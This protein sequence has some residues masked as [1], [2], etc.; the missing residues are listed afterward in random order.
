[1][2]A[3]K[4]NRDHSRITIPRIAWVLIA[5]FMGI[6]IWQQFQINQLVQVSSKNS[7]ES[8]QQA[9]A[10]AQS[11]EQVSSIQ[12]DSQ[13]QINSRKVGINK[14]RAGE[15]LAQRRQE[16]RMLGPQATGQRMFEELKIIAGEDQ[17]V[18]PA[19]LKILLH[20]GRLQRELTE[21]S[22]SGEIAQDALVS[23]IERLRM[24]SE[25]KAESLLTPSQFDRYREVRQSW[26]RGRT[27]PDRDSRD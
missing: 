21:K 11:V 23:A 4:Q 13:P 7:I 16:A 27:H 12:T 10:K 1:M 5:L 22:S 17:Q 8:T 25:T 9:T 3:E 6:L 2:I 20:E 19:L 14:K 15:L 24:E 26:K 18:L